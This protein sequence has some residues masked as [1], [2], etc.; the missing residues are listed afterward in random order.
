M[1]ALGFTERQARFLVLML[2]HSGVCL[3]RQYRAFAGVAHGRH[4]L[5]FFAKLI[6]GGLATTDLA[7]PA[8]AGRICH[9][10]YKPWYRLLGEPDHRHRKPMSVG[11]AVAI[12]RASTLGLVRIAAAIRPTS[13]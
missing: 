2:E 1:A 9:V 11:R 10:Q 4:S 7:A 12:M 6:A 3:P 8:H 13:S 5:A